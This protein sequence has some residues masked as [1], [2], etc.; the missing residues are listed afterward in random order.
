MK[1]LLFAYAAM[2]QLGQYASMIADNPVVIVP[3]ALYLVRK[4]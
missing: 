3:L 2:I 1:L 4:H